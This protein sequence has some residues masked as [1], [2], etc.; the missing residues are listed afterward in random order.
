MLHFLE[1]LAAETRLNN[2]REDVG[3]ER[4]V[5]FSGLCDYLR[6]FCVRIYLNMSLVTDYFAKLNVFVLL[7]EVKPIEHHFKKCL[8]FLVT[9]LAWEF[10]S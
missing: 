7:R 9:S 2:V 3:R 8:S 6:T 1:P 10:W 5:L 4:V